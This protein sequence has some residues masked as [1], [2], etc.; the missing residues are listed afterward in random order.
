[1][2]RRLVKFLLRMAILLVLLTAVLAGATFLT[3]SMSD[4]AVFAAPGRAA[5]T[6]VEAGGTVVESSGLMAIAKPSEPGYIVRL[7]SA[8][9]YLVIDARVVIMWR[10]AVRWG[11]E[12]LERSPSLR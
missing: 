12:M 8:G 3:A 6:A 7:Y 9:A 11:G 1:M 4:V 5:E 10:A 2:V